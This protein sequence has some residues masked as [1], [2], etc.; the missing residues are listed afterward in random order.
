[1]SSSSSSQAALSENDSHTPPTQAQPDL[2]ETATSPR[3]EP[4][5]KTKALSRRKSIAPPVKP[6]AANPKKPASSKISADAEA[7]APVKTSKRA[8]TMSTAAAKDDK[9]RKKTRHGGAI[10]DCQAALDALEADE[11]LVATL[12][13]GDV[14]AFL[15]RTRSDYGFSDGFEVEDIDGSFPASP[16]LAPTR[17]AP[18]H[19]PPH[20]GLSWSLNCISERDRAFQKLKA[21]NASLAMVETKLKGYYLVPFSTW[22]SAKKGTHTKYSAQLRYGTKEGDADFDDRRVV[23]AVLEGYAPDGKGRLC[24][25]WKSEKAP[26]ARKEHETIDFYLQKQDLPAGWQAPAVAAG[27]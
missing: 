11:L 3:R 2:F 22:A 21:P 9:K 26:W 8:R 25:G 10:D 5:S 20:Y 14:E 12:P 4:V 18:T 27:L 16:K 17:Y 6:K 13:S 24:N 1:M 15:T 23:H 19:N 7:E